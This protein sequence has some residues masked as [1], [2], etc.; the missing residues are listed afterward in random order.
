MVEGGEINVAESNTP[1]QLLVE[2]CLS[3]HAAHDSLA[4]THMTDLTQQGFG[5][6][7]YESG[8][9]AAP[10]YT[11]PASG[12]SG[13]GVASPRWGASMAGAAGSALSGAGHAISGAGS[14]ISGA[15]SP[16]HRGHGSESMLVQ[17][18]LFAAALFCRGAYQVEVHHRPPCGAGAL[19]IE[20]QPHKSAEH[21]CL[22]AIHSLLPGRR[23]V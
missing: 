14:A 15:L 12:R 4:A 1:H 21:Q 19:F 18:P 16:S 8:L 17:V 6:P 5:N 11:P 2:Q 23:R 7:K 13:G 10:S 22:T 9:R 3:M 20:H